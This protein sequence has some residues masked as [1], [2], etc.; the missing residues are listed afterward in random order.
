PNSL[1]PAELLLRYGTEAQKEH[2]L[3]R[4]ARG[5]ELPCFGLTNPHAGS[6]AASIPD[7]G[8]VCEGEFEGRTVL[9]MRVTWEKRYITLGP[10]ATLLGLAFR[11][12]DPDGL[13]GDRR[14]VGITLALIPTDHP[15]VDI[16]RR[17]YPARQPFHNGPNSGR[18]VFIPMDWI[19]GGEARCGDGWRMLMNCLAAGRSISLPAT[20][21]AA[22]KLAAWTTG[23]YASVRQQFNL[24]LHR[25]EGVQEAM[26]R[27]AANA[28]VVDA[29]REVTAGALDRGEEPAVLS[30]VLKYQATERMRQ[31]INDAMDVHGGRAVCD[32]PSNYLFNAYMSVPVA[33]TV[34]GANILTRSL[35]VFGQGALRCHPYLLKELE[36]A[37]VV[38]PA[39]SLRLFDKAFRGH[40]GHVC[41]NLARATFRNLTG[42]VLG[43]DPSVGEANYWYAQLE[44]AS[45]SFALLGDC[46]LAQLGGALKRREMLSGRF[47]DVLGEL[48]LLSAALKAFEDRGRRSSELALLE[49]AMRDGL[50]RVQQAFDAILENLPARGTAWWL[51]RAVFPLGRRWQRP[52][53]AL[54]R[55]VATD[56]AESVELREMFAAGLYRD[57]APDGVLGRLE[58]AMAL[59]VA[60]RGLL[61]RVA[62][63]RRAGRLDPCN[64]DLPA[65]A[66]A[67]GVVSAA[68]A[69]Q[70]GAWWRALRLAI[71]VDDFAPDELW[72]T[73]TGGQRRADAA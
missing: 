8:V 46:A 17:H 1:G 53:D 19:I 65:A 58:H 52:S 36:A 24:P 68:E 66:L 64:D 3:P 47:A 57:T 9:G 23:A 54:T 71:D 62:D 40:L 61:E 22:L 37:A 7:F 18:E 20:S 49:Y 55:Q 45:A 6:D 5:E 32:G 50:Y 69:E 33:I 34:E 12:Y 21:T 67:A 73:A 35:I 72:G 51:R 16:G 48:Y 44:R 42:G 56:L 26:A 28:Y 63:A 11:L 15:G 13:L 29:A 30:A 59:A 27:I 38:N 39:E 31:A 41:A 43:S 14:D 10:V 2:Y 25:F 4:L 60:C 70:L